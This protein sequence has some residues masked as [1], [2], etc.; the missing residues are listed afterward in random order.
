MTTSIRDVAVLAGV[1][2]GTVSNVLNRPEAVAA[3]TRQRVLKAIATLGYVR[4]DSARQLRAGR[5]RT[6]AMVLDIA[7]PLL[8]DVARGAERAADRANV[9]LVLFGNED[10]PARERHQLQHVEEQRVLGTLISPVDTCP[11]SYLEQLIRRGMPVVLVDPGSRRS[12]RCLVHVDDV[13]GGRLAGTHLLEQGHRRLAFVGGPMAGRQVG[14]R[15]RGF[16]TVLAG[17][18]KRPDLLPIETPELTVQ[19]GREAAAGIADL[20]SARRPT[21]AFCAS[22]LLALGVLQELTRRGIRV[23]QEVALVG[24][25]D[26]YLAAAAAIPLSS[27]RQPGEELGRAAAELLLEKASGPGHRHRQLVFQPELVVRASSDH[28]PS[29]RRAI[30]SYRSS[31]EPPQKRGG[32]Y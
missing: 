12:G 20:P 26:S 8:V 22:D 21:A 24:Y 27:V 30:D 31:D 10:N 29:R 5:S 15:H 9:A 14:D 28:R 25:G 32:G 18:G 3:T 17:D 23:P 6:I 13:A 16:A 7:N 11:E 4:N 2:A 19:A 1:S